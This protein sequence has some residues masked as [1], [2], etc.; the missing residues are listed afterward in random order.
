[1]KK[2]EILFTDGRTR[3]TSP[4]DTI[5]KGDG[6]TAEQYIADCRENADDDWNTMLAGGTV[7][8]I[9]AEE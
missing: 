1:M 4:I 8:V 7:S 2:Y 5:F 3:A 6:Y 9:V